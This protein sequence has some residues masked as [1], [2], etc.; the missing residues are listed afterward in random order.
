MNVIWLDIEY[1]ARNDN[2]ND[3]N[4]AFENEKT[5]LKLIEAILILD[6]AWQQAPRVSTNQ[7]K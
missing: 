5:S 7:K 2:D 3:N 6:P 4:A 1:R